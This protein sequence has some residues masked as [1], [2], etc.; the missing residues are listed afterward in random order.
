MRLFIGIKTGCEAYLTALQQELLKYGR[1]RLTDKDNLHLTLK[2]LGEVEPNRV[3]EACD[4]MAKVH[5]E[6]I[7]L[8]CLGVHIFG[9]NGI[10]S[11]GI[12]GNT[13]ALASLASRLESALENI[14]FPKENRPFKAHITLARDFRANPSADVESIPF[15]GKAFTANEITLFESTRIGGKLVYV[16]LYMQRLQ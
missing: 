1:G 7:D 5:G 12:G 14:G 10:V 16:L 6:P 9:R 8:K 15:S 3:K 4:A 11:C 13:S 2:F